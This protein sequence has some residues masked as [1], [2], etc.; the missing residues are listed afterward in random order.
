MRSEKIETPEIK[1]TNDMKLCRTLPHPLSAIA[2]ACVFF[3]SDL[4]GY[5]TGAYLPVTGGRVTQAG[6]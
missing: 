5:V 1:S 6:V 3:M 2:L 4:A